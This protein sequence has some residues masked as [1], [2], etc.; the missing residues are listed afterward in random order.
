MDKPNCSYYWNYPCSIQLNE[1]Q[2]LPSLSHSSPHSHFSVSSFLF[3]NGRLIE[4]YSRLL[5]LE[6]REPF[7]LL[8]AF[9]F[10]SRECIKL[11][12]YL[13]IA[14][15]SP[16]NWFLASECFTWFISPCNLSAKRSICLSCSISSRTFRGICSESHR[17]LSNPTPVALDDF[18]HNDC[19]CPYIRWWSKVLRCFKRAASVSLWLVSAKHFSKIKSNFFGLLN[20]VNSMIWHGSIYNQHLG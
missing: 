19:K 20:N 16:Q 2:L 1:D 10:L 6:Y 9:F 12:P 14:E 5:Y 15:F 8:L 18:C 7:P 4:F 3:S 11:F 17:L 13:S